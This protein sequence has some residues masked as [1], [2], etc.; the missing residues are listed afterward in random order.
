MMLT[1]REAIET[2][3]QQPAYDAAA[4]VALD[5]WR[6]R[7]RHIAAA[8]LVAEYLAVP[9]AHTLLPCRCVCVW[10][11]GTRVKLVTLTHTHE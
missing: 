6:S 9:Y 5:A 8:A 2:A 7:P 1:G 11:G 4:L 10:G 3:R